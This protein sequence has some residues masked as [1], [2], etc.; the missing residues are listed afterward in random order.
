[1]FNKLLGAADT[2][3]QT[4]DNNTTQI[5][6]RPAAQISYSTMPSTGHAQRTT[7]FAEMLV[8]SITKQ[9]TD[10]QQLR[11]MRTCVGGTLC[12][13]MTDCGRQLCS[14]TTQV[15]KQPS[16]NAAL[17]QLAAR[18]KHTSSTSNNNAFM[19]TRNTRNSSFTTLQTRPGELPAG[20]IQIHRGVSFPEPCRRPRQLSACWHC[21]NTPHS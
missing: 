16:C 19:L 9:L 6:K 3:A 13:R 20:P 18:A 4:G 17:Q 5:S 10:V 2:R 14:K 15:C 7:Q 11:R 8:I 12:Q 1:M 21:T